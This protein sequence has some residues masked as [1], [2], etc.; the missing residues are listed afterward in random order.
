MLE[1]TIINRPPQNLTYQVGWPY[2]SIFCGATWDKK[3]DLRIEWYKGGVKMAKFDD[4]I[5]LET[6]ATGPPRILYINNIRITDGGIYT[7]HAYTKVGDVISESKASA[8]L[9]V[10]GKINISVGHYEK[11]FSRNKDV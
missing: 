5:Y 6:R 9:T 1:P 3:L 11:S 2:A 7:C 4:R 10:K 8:R